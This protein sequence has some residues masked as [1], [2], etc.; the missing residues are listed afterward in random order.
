MRTRIMNRP[1]ALAMN[2]GYRWKKRLF[3]EP[4]RAQLEKLRELIGVVL[5]VVIGVVLVE[6]VPAEQP[7]AQVSEPAHA[8]SQNRPPSHLGTRCG[9]ISMLLRLN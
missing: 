2:E 4:R 6:L 9:T 1:Q 5:L 3:S 7:V 8:H